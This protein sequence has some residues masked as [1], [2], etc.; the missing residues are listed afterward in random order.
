MRIDAQI[1]AVTVLEILLLDS[2]ATLVAVAGEQLAH[3]L[4]RLVIGLHAHFQPAHHFTPA[5]VVVLFAP[6]RLTSDES[7]MLTLW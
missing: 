2:D 4:D 7:P 6:P 1:I 5:D 3:R